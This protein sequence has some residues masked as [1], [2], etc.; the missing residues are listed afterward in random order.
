MHEVS[1]FVCLQSPEHITVS[2]IAVWRQCKSRSVLLII[3]YLVL[4]Y[5]SIRV[6]YISVHVV[7][8]YSIYSQSTSTIVRLFREYRLIVTFT[9]MEIGTVIR[10][11]VDQCFY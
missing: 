10:T 5:L 7:L 1:M 6:R 2:I 4:I 3:K 11:I 8:R 9:I